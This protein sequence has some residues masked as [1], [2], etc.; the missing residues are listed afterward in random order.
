[1]ERRPVR[2]QLQSPVDLD[3][4]LIL[5]PSPDCD[6]G[7]HGVNVGVVRLYG[8]DGIGLLLRVVDLS[9][10]KQEVAEFGARLQ[11]GRL[12]VHGVRQFGVCRG[13][14]TQVHVRVR[15][16]KVSVGKTLVDLQSVQ[17][18]NRGF[19][20]LSLGAVPVSALQILVLAHIWIA[21]AASQESDRD[22]ERGHA[23][24]SPP[25]HRSPPAIETRLNR[26]QRTFHCLPSS[27]AGQGTAKP[28]VLCKTCS[29]CQPLSSE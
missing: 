6:D 2:F 1:M 29:G 22:K 17:I 3:Q 11:V 12:Q 28:E 20:V 26:L 19:P 24:R 8:H 9:T 7:E 18:L 15:Q 27:P 14:L 13:E 16:R 21:V 25:V 10:G 4:R 23:K 5:V